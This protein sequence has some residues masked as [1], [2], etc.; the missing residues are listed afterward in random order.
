MARD[1]KHMPADLKKRLDKIERDVNK[2]EREI[3]TAAALAAKQ[4]QE[5]EM[6]QDAGG[7]L[8]LSRVRSGKGARIGARFDRRGDGMNIRA[9]GPVPLVAND[10]RAHKIPKVR[11]TQRPLAIPGI[12]VRAS[13]N[14]PGTKGK[15]TW[16]D[17]RQKAIPVIRTIIGRKSDSVVIQS[18]R[19]G[20]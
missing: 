19:A 11:K 13:V 4:V 6:K 17:G 2:S 9:T 16:D 5:V 20:G 8:R 10:V 15:D 14:H 12:G 18:F 3:E 7:D 1:I